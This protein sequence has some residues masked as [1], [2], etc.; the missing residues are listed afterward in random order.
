MYAFF[1]NYIYQVKIITLYNHFLHMHILTIC[2]PKIN[3]HISASKALLGVNLHIN[4]VTESPH[5]QFLTKPPH[6][7]EALANDTSIFN[8]KTP[9]A[10]H[11]WEILR[12]FFCSVV[13]I[14]N[15][16]SMHLRNYKYAKTCHKLRLPV[17]NQ[18]IVSF[19]NIS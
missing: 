15:S 7:D 5:D 6:K 9:W 2:N 12:S 14:C 3:S 17:K 13:S 8:L 16:L 19:P 11:F 10:R 1:F 18:N 4:L